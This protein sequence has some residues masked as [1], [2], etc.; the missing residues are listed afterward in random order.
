[1]SAD[2][3]LR[4][5]LEEILDSGR[6]PEVVTHECPELLPQVLAELRHVRMVEAQVEALFPE[7]DGSS[8]TIRESTLTTGE[9]P[10]IAGYEIESVLGRGGM[11]VVYGGRHLQLNRPVAIKMLL[12]GACATAAERERFLREAE[13]AARLQHPNIVPVYDVGDC[14]GRLYFTMEFVVGGTLAEELAGVPQEPRKAAELLATL[15]DAVRVAHEGG[16]LHRDL[17]PSNILL[18]ADGTPKIS[19]FGLARQLEGTAGLTLTGAPLGTPSYMSPEQARGDLRALGPYVDIYALGALLYELLTGRPPFHAESS[20]ATL[21]QV[22]S[23][24]PVSPKRLNASVPRDLETICLKCLQK[25]PARRYAGAADL[26]DDVRRFLRNE[27]IVARPIGIP[28]RMLRWTRRNPAGAALLFMGVGL[29]FITTIF[30]MKE[31][32]LASERRLERAAWHERLQFVL[33]LEQEGRYREARAILGRDPAGG[34]GHL[35]GEIAAAIRDLDVAEKLERIRISRGQYKPGGGLDYDES[36][37]QYEAIF[38]EADLGSFDEDPVIVGERLKESSVREAVLATLDDWAVCAR[39][40]PRLWIFGVARTLDPDPWRDRVRHVKQWGSKEELERLAMD[41]NVRE[42][43]VTLMVAMGT[44]WRLLGGDPAKFLQ[45]VYQV[46]P[47][48]FWLNFEL[49]YLFDLKGDSS[50]AIGYVMTA[51]ALR[52]DASAAHFNLAVTLRNIGQTSDALHHFQR[53]VELEPKHA[54]AQLRIGELLLE[55]G[56]LGEASSQFQ[57]AAELEPS[58]P[59]PKLRLREIL[60]H[61]GRVDEAVAIWAKALDSDAS[62]YSECDGYAELCLILG[63]EDEYRRAC[64]KLLTRF[65]ST[66][67]PRECECMGRACLLAPPSAELLQ[68]SVALTDRALAADKSTYPEWLYPY[69]LFANGLAEYRSGRYESAIAICEGEAAE[70][71]GPAPELVTAMAQHRLGNEDAARQALAKANEEFDGER[72]PVPRRDDWL[73][74]ILRREALEQIGQIEK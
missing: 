29:L 56:Q 1:M 8:E 53:T 52:P 7:S 73:Y 10:Q 24:E 2:P 43:P 49:G 25:D 18:T 38:R 71:L 47:N 64:D 62:T 13:A 5:L 41:V 48:D 33:Q 67:D 23:Q 37:R 19:D 63:R 27:P 11:G 3:R 36:S 72:D 74:F 44:R 34:S 28:G 61:Q 42:Q 57:R 31:I 4:R 14:E 20:S 50:S 55:N 46:Y 58:S 15:S 45:R 32:A 51:V 17:K 40:G 30:A 66:T 16:I 69:F 68:Q 6:S 22:I 54:L 21:R 60:L 35:R 26:R 9:L 39:D 12:A 59:E 70:I 65:G